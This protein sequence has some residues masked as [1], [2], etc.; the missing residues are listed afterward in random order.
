MYRIK[1]T[2][3]YRLYEARQRRKAWSTH[4][5]TMRSRRSALSGWSLQTKGASGSCVR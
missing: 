4:R 5:R 3:A 1:I 2:G